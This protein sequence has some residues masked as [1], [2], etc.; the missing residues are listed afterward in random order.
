[1]GQTRPRLDVTVDYDGLHSNLRSLRERLPEV[2]E[3]AESD[4]GLIRATLGAEI[5]A[6]VS[7]ATPQPRDL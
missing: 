5:L 7:F 1:M 6:T 2:R 3:T 4:D